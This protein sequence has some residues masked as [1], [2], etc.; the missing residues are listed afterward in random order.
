MHLKKS[1]LE[2]LERKFR[3]NLINSIS[4]IKPANLIGSRS[5]DGSD[6]VAIFSSVVHLGSNPAQLGLILRPQ[7]EA[8]SD[9]HLNIKETGFY[10]INHVSADFAEK[11][12]YTSAKLGR[13][14]SEFERMKLEKETIDD[15]P[16]PFVKNS[17]VKMGMKHLQSIPLPN[18][19]SLIIG[20][21]E[22]L[23]CPE[24]AIN[25]LG[26]LDLEAYNL[27]GISGLNTYYGLKKIDSFPYVRNNEIPDFE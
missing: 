9:T 21:V 19:C 7:I 6:N 22:L 11:A 2:N 13:S 26:Q 17:A 23:I 18:D 24:N 3:L 5:L 4:G 16:A 8:Q 15:F 12:H 27:V 25:E 14:E 1:D 10:T 20:T